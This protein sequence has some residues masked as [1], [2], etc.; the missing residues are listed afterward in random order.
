MPYS[1]GAGNVWF[2]GDILEHMSTADAQSVVGHLLQHARLLFLS[3]LLDYQP[4]GI[5]GS[6]PFEQHVVDDYSNAAVRRSFP[7]IID[8]SVQTIDTWIIGAYALT[9]HEAIARKL[10]RSI[11]LDAAQ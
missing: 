6:N 1:S 2:C 8:G 3:L 5:V 10:Q 11:G 9:R 7:A 4:Q